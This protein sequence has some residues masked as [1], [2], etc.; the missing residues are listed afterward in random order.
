MGRGTQQRPTG[1]GPEGFGAESWTTRQLAEFLSVVI[2]AARSPPRSV[3]PEGSI[4]VA[5]L[6]EASGDLRFERELG[7]LGLCTGMCSLVGEEGTLLVARTGRVDFSKEEL[8]LLR[9]MA[10]CSPSPCGASA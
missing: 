6:V 9:G 5:D 1:D 2:R 3:S 4:P 10:A 8:D 7:E